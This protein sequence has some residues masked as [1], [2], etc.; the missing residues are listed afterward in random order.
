VNICDVPFRAWQC[1]P[2]EADWIVERI[3]TKG[4]AK[5]GEILYNVK[6]H[7]FPSNANFWEPITNLQGCLDMVAQFN[8]STDALPEAHKEW[9]YLSA[10]VDRHGHF[11]SWLGFS[12]SA[13]SWEPIMRLQAVRCHPVDQLQL[14]IAT[15]KSCMS[16][17]RAGDEFA[18]VRCMILLI[19]SPSSKAEVNR[20]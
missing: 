2:D 10:P 4:Q 5:D 1:Q 6:W 13:N 12:S 3:V 11:V 17:E 9:Q 19:D 7:G 8:A 15:S 14:A 18:L 20:K 16:A